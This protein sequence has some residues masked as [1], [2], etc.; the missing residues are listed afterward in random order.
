MKCALVFERTKSTQNIQ[1]EMALENGGS[2]AVALEIGSGAAE[3]G[4]GVGGWLRIT[5]AALGGGGN[6]R[7]CNDGIGS[8][9]VKDEGLLLR[10]WRP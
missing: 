5:A 6:R 4:G 10:R 9:V 1:L 3:L 7:T 8:S 2:A